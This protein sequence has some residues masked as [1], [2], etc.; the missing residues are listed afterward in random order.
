MSNGEANV[1]H[2]VFHQT[3]AFGFLLP[4]PEDYRTAPIVFP[5]H[6]F[7]FAGDTEE[8]RFQSHSERI[9]RELG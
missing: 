1:A 6:G 3:H 4:F 9:Y 8:E 5:L 7:P 2:E